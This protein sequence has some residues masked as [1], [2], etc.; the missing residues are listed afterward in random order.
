MSFLLTDLFDNDYFMH[1]GKRFDVDLSYDNILNFYELID[2]HEYDVN[3]R[4]ITSLEI[5]VEES[6]KLGLKSL[7]EAYGLFKFL[8]LKFLDI[9]LDKNKKQGENESEEDDT[10]DTVKSFDY[11]KDAEVIYASFMQAYK[12]DLFEQQGILHWKKFNALLVNLPDETAF[13]KIVGFRVMKVPT[14]KEGA[15]KDYIRYVRQMKEKYSL[16]TRSVEERINDSLSSFAKS[17]K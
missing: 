10:G 4:I 15:S 13:K 14:E 9:D 11:N 3:F 8:L 6:D 1:K 12:M 7:E 17:L 5:I 16:D 2:N